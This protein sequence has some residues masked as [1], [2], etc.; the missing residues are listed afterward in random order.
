MIKYC[1]EKKKNCLKVLDWC[2]E[3]ALV[4]S[5]TQST[6]E[7]LVMSLFVMYLPLQKILMRKHKSNCIMSRKN[8]YIS[9]LPVSIIWLALSV[10]SIV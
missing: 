3:T 2:N 10:D 5:N 7:V 6:V 8:Q 4:E 9:I 1:G